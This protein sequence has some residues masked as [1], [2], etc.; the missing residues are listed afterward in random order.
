MA[1]NFLEIDNKDDDKIYYGQLGMAHMILNYKNTASYINANSK[2]KNKVC[3]INT[4]CYNC[5]TP[6]E[7]V[8]NWQFHKIEK[9]ILKYFLPYCNSDFTLFDLSEKSEAANKYRSFGQFLI[10]AKNQN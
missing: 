5:T 4:Y 6:E 9:G 2:F 1:A 7:Q 8:S 3:V 10:I